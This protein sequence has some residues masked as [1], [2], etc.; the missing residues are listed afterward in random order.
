MI[1][2]ETIHRIRLGD[3]SAF[4][5]LCRELYPSLLAYA[6]LF[7]NRD[8]AEDIVQDVLFEFWKGR[9]RLDESGNIQ[10]YLMRSVYNRCANS[11]KRG[12]IRQ[13]LYSNHRRDEIAR[14]TIEYLSPDNNPVIAAVFSAEKRKM[15]EAAVESLSPRC[16]EVFRLSF[17]DNLTNPQISEMLGIDLRTVEN[18]KYL[19]LKEL[20]VKLSMATD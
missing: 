12:G 16:R 7:L 14:M 18:H 15:I 4:D 19:A 6:S 11:L 2:S 8:W 5:G 3:R 13:M 1:G 9:E 10:G 20:R 17:Y